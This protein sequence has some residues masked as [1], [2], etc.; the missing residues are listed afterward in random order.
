M[1]APIVY[2]I[3]GSPF[4]RSAMLAL[5]EKSA[6]YEFSEVAMGTSKQEPHLEPED[7]AG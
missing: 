4:M 6:A 7:R 5:E 1:A 3:K 2:G